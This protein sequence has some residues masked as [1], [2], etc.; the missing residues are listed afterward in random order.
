MYTVS[1]YTLKLLKRTN[2]FMSL[3]MSLMFSQSKHSYFKTLMSFFLTFYPAI[4]CIT[5]CEWT[6]RDS[7]LSS[8]QR[9]ITAM[10]TSSLGF[11]KA[12]ALLWFE[13]FNHLKFGGV[14]WRLS[15]G[16]TFALH[17]KNFKNLIKFD[18]L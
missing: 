1:F 17:S 6:L 11:L 16:E 12:A 7:G 8:H 14:K 15:P 13:D 3:V 9:S 4:C 5:I 2:Y 18:M 10:K